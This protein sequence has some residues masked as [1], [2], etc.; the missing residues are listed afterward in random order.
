VFHAK[1]SGHIPQSRKERTVEFRS[2][3]PLLQAVHKGDKL[4]PQDILI[5]FRNNVFRFYSVCEDGVKQLGNKIVPIVMDLNDIE[6]SE[7]ADMLASQGLCD[8]LRRIME[9]RVFTL[10]SPT[11]IVIAPTS[12]AGS[13]AYI[14][15]LKERT[16]LPTEN[17]KR[18][19]DRFASV[20]Q[21][22][23]EAC[24]DM[25]QDRKDATT[26]PIFNPSQLKQVIELC[27]VYPYRM[28]LETELRIILNFVHPNTL[29]ITSVMSGI[30]SYRTR[31][32][33]EYQLQALSEL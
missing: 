19:Q 23:R 10:L 25:V 24:N 27:A 18:I 30:R 8:G 6:R 26:V 7:A 9:R 29:V 17:G 12:F 13:D 2:I 14:A 22:I 33:F 16:Y 11:Q 32:T 5:M 3:S 1:E 4:N 15:W 20:I 31:A 28:W 21:D